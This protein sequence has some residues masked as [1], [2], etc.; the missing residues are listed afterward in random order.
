MEKINLSN[1]FLFFKEIFKIEKLFFMFLII[2]SKYL[3][4][5]NSYKKISCK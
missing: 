4:A 5:F 2:N 3:Q 1:M